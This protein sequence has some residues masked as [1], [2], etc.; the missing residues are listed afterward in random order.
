[1]YTILKFW[2]TFYVMCYMPLHILLNWFLNLCCTTCILIISG[3]VCYDVWCNHI[4]YMGYSMIL[5]VCTTT[6]VNYMCTLIF[7]NLPFLH[8]FSVNNNKPIKIKLCYVT[9]IQIVYSVAY[10]YVHAYLCVPECNCFTVILILNSTCQKYVPHLYTVLYIFP[11]V[12][13]IMYIS[14]NSMKIIKNK[15]YM[16]QVMTITY[17]L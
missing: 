16:V 7:V 13:L 8:A 1:M 17:K 6:Y 14:H 15:R 2:F 9:R 3:K 4:M 12:W 11:M 5:H 10:T